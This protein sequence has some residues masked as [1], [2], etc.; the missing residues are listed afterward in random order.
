MGAPGAFSSSSASTQPLYSPKM[1]SML[2]R[3]DSLVDFER[4]MR[5]GSAPGSMRLTRTSV[6]PAAQLLSRLSSPQHHLSA[7]HVTGSKGKGSVATL[8]TAALIR[9]PFLVSVIGTYGSPH[10]ERVNERIRLNGRPIPDDDLARALGQVMDAR[11]RAPVLTQ[12]TWFDVM[13]VAGLVAFRRAQ[14]KWAVVEVGMGGRLDSTNVLNAPVAVVTN[15]HMEH[16]E[17]IGPTVRDI[18]YEKAGIIAA[19]ADVVCGLPEN[20]ELADIFREEAESKSPPARI[21]FCPAEEGSS[22]LDHNLLMSRAAVQAVAKREGVLGVTGEDLLPRDVA[23]TAL[24]NLP[25]RQELF[26]VPGDADEPTVPLRVLLDGAHVPES[27]ALVLKELKPA[28]PPVVLVGVGKEKDLT[29]ICNVIHAVKPKHIFATAAGTES[30]YLPPEDLAQIVRKTGVTPVSAVE[31]ADMALAQAIDLAHVNDAD[32]VVIGSLHL[33]GRVR[34][35]LR[36]RQDLHLK[37]NRDKQRQAQ[38]SQL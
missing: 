34:P 17:I 29:G 15:V 9:A 11:E 26:L 13:S 16:A 20:H 12:S 5:G 37:S 2:K 38:A 23:E 33:A 10:V 27:V 25:A 18:A 3:L 30:P 36:M 7:V 21:Q 32:L 14:A 31:D 4:R 19:G 24:G 28:R 35:S 1:Q 8:I 22:L 6:Q